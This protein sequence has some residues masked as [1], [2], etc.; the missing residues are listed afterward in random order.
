[1]EKQFVTCDIALKLKELGFDE[2]CLGFFERKNLIYEWSKRY[3]YRDTIS[4]PLWQEVIDWFIE[5]YNYN[6][7]ILEVD[8]RYTDKTKPFWLYSIQGIGKNTSIILDN[9]KY[10][11]YYKA[12]ESAILKAI[13]VIQK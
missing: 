7:V 3:I 8:P 1:M 5:K 12:R 11:T 9:L 2:R 4:A 6:I 10:D 13:E